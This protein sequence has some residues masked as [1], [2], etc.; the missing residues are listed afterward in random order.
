MTNCELI[1]PD[2][3]DDMA[4]EYE[5]KGCLF[6]VVLRVAENSYSLSFYDPT[7]LKQDIDVLL[8]ERGLFF[9]PNMIVVPSIT[10]VAIFGAATRLAAQ[11]S[12]VSC[13]IPM[14]T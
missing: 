14:V 3:F 5:A 8:R 2:D 12:W 6:G 1:L 11:R 4:W 9:E 13:L 7:R 10:K